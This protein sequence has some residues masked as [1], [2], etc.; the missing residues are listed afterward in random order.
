MKGEMIHFILYRN[1][2][3]SDSLLPNVVRNSTVEAM[4]FKETNQQHKAELVLYSSDAAATESFLHSDYLFLHLNT[5][6]FV[7]NH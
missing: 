3:R 4:L 6:I 7:K 1:S 2:Y 5:S